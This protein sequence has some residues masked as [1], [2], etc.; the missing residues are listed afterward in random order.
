MKDTVWKL[1]E[2]TGNTAYYLLYKELTKDG[3]NHKSH[4]PKNN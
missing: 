2:K 4:R 3:S 1:F